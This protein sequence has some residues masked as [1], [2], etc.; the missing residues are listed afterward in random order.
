M[1]WSFLTGVA[2]AALCAGAAFAADA[3]A[4]KKAPEPPPP[5]WI[6]TLTIDGFVDAGV[7]INPAT[8]YNNINFGQLFTDRA[9]LPVLNQALLTIQRPLDPKATGFDYGFKFQTFIGADARYSHFYGQLDYAMKGLNQVT[10]L[11]ANALFHL[12]ILTQGGM[13]VKIGQFVTYNGSEVI[14]AKDN[15]F[16]THEYIFN[17]GPFQHTGIMTT[18]HVSEWLDVYAGVTTGLNTSIG[19]AGDNQNSPSAYGGF[20]LNFFDG[21]LTI[22][23]FSH[24]GPEN[25]K[26]LDPL[27]VGW[28]YGV[29]GGVPAACACNPT[30]TWRF[31][32]N[33]TT[34]WKP[35]E[36]LT[37][38][39]DL[40]YYRE[41]GWN[42]ISITGLPSATLSALD[43]AYGTNFSGLP[44]R[45]QGAD[46][47]GVSQ[48]VSYKLNDVFKIN[49]RVEFFR[50][51]K[52]FFVAAYPGY[53]DAVNFAHGYWS[54]TI[55]RPSGQGTSY[56]ALT[57]GT[58]ITPELPKMPY[59]TGV[60]LR[61]ELRW[62]TAVNG[63]APFFGSSPGAMKKSQGL[64]SMDVIVPFSIR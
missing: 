16:Y 18:T 61:P 34:T 20:G 13:D 14:P 37:F 57:L 28:P 24:S 64:I 46:A 21:K 5:M 15:L 40:A 38:I 23:G 36:N 35:T 62:D 27:G 44:N 30:N 4:K 12:P 39:T 19:W 3:P 53:V 25:A 17:F 58:T 7:S 11:E 52:N 6:D 41:S 56:L 22:L 47:Y 48:T 54:T 42:P 32:N 9:N 63:V 43:G 8:P 31:Y 55:G 29:V 2:V 49:G 33:I 45:P 26:Q 50:D 10:I 59:I 51:N 60:I 1:K